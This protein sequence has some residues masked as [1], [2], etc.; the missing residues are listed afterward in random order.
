MLPEAVPV[1]AAV[2]VP[3]E[4]F[5]DESRATTV[6]TVFVDAV[7]ISSSKSA[8]KFVTLVVDATVNGAVPVAWVEINVVALALPTT[9]NFSPG[10]LVAIPTLAPSACKIRF[11]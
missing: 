7:F 9:S 3:A 6:E 1:K 4:K 10:V 8:F 5:P 2:M 11:L